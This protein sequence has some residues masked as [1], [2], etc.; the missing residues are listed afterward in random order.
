MTNLGR[1]YSPEKSPL[2]KRT[3][4]IASNMNFV[5]DAAM[6][7]LGWIVK[8]GTILE[9][10]TALTSIEEDPKAGVKKGM[11]TNASGVLMHDLVLEAGVHKYN[12]GVLIKGVVY[13]DVM[14]EVNGDVSTVRD[15][16]EGHG[17]LFYNVITNKQ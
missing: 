2:H 11:G 1:V 16:L 14:V 5:D 15:V 12:V 13:D 10:N 4:S 7:A 3:T 17:I 8:A 6:S 9:S